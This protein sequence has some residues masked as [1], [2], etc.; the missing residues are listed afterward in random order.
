VTLSPDDGR[1]PDSGRPGGNRPAQLSAVTTV[2]HATLLALREAIAAGRY[3]PGQPL[4][5]E[6]LARDFG[7][8]VPPVREAL[9]TLETEGQVV[10]VPRRGYSVSRLS[11]AELRETYRIRDL[12]ETEAITRAVGSLTRDDLA[13]MRA[14]VRDMDRADRVAD[15]AALT[16]ANRRFH[17]TV[18]DAAAMPRL[19]DMIRMLWDGTDHYRSRYFATPAHRE[20]VRAEHAEIMRAVAR[21]DAGAAAELS[22]QHRDHALNALCDALPAE[23]MGPA[24]NAVPAEQDANLP[25]TPAKTARRASPR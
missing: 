18:F 17:F 22:R 6:T 12:L 7:V 4:R 3:Q 24:E 16:A 10:Y 2:Q 15:V 14:T 13:R 21:G 11:R 8:S 5:Q 1:H 23:N 20:Q 9:K 19:A 25:G